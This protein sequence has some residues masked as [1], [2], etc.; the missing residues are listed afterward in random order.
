MADLTSYEWTLK[1][2]NDTPAIVRI[3]QD[4]YDNCEQVLLVFY[5]NGTVVQQRRDWSLGGYREDAYR[6][7]DEWLNEHSNAGFDASLSFIE[8]NS[9]LLEEE[10]RENV[11]LEAY[12]LRPDTCSLEGIEQISL[13]FSNV[14]L[15]E[16]RVV[17][18][19]TEK[20]ENLSLQ[21][22]QFAVVRSRI[23]NF[24]FDGNQ[25]R[26]LEYKLDLVQY[27]DLLDVKIFCAPGQVADHLT[28]L[29]AL[30]E[31]QKAAEAVIFEGIRPLRT[32]LGNLLNS[33]DGMHSVRSNSGIKI[34]N[35][36]KANAR[37]MSALSESTQT[38]RTYAEL[39]R[40]QKDWSELRAG[41]DKLLSDYERINPD[42]MRQELGD[43]Q[44]LLNA[45]TD[46][47][48]Q[49][50]GS[51]IP[52][53]TAK[54]TADVIFELA[55]GVEFYAVYSTVLRAWFTALND[56]VVKLVKLIR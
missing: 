31:S 17:R 50:E 1:A 27:T 11:A 54:A 6:Y 46:R 43:L 26:K 28:M 2:G 24:G 37:L 44:V 7:H 16:N 10:V 35:P 47:L 9:T 34:T 48:A 41:V 55:Q 19:V 18:A 45:F 12:F 15:T 56:S 38:E 39:I 32:Y 29:Q 20:F 13:E 14:F 42:A 40:Q 5:S 4:D 30:Q 36:K 51:G 49:A 21:F 23:K 22:Q 33:R 25:L 8:L 53:A 52:A 3:A